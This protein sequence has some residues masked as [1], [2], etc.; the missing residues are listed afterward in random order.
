MRCSP[1]GLRACA[2][3]IV[4]AYRRRHNFQLGDIAEHQR[5][6]RPMSDRISAIRRFSLLPAGL[7][8]LGQLALAPIHAG[9]R[10][11][12]VI[13]NADY[14]QAPLRNPVNDAR[15]LGQTLERLGFEVIRVENAT[16]TRMEQAVIEFTSR[17]KANTSGVFYYAGHGVQVKGRNYLIPV[18][19]TLDSEREVRLEA[20]DVDLV[21]GELEYAGNR[22][23]IV[24]LDACRNNPFER[25]FR[26]RSRGLAAIDA[27]RGTLIAYATAPGSVAMD[28][29]GSNGVYTEELL[30]A[31]NEPGLEVEEVFKQVRIRVSK[32]T[33]NQQIPWESSS[34]TGE[35]VFHPG[36]P[37]SAAGGAAA[38]SRNAELLFWESVKASDNADVYRAY[39]AQY[40]DGLFTSLARI[41]LAELEGTKAAARLS[42]SAPGEGAAAPAPA[43][44][45]TGAGGSGSQQI[46]ALAPPPGAGGDRE[47]SGPVKV[48]LLPPNTGNLCGE[49]DARGEVSSVAGSFFRDHADLELTHAYQG[50]RLGGAELPYADDYW[51]GSYTVKVPNESA[52]YRVGGST[53]ADAALMYVYG[54]VLM[55]GAWDGGTG[56]VSVYLFDLRTQTVYHRE[57]T[58]RDMRENTEQVVQEYLRGRAG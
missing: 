21:L 44:T 46:A 5:S 24:I 52:V 34:L 33:N 25:R 11:A 50:A 18:D 28:G 49:C 4:F 39:L 58:R 30:H 38:A 54:S 51:Q 41:R 27:A 23:N 40:P 31:L 7:V 45:A 13:G 10:V 16:R 57:G 53:D 29:D 6:H 32:R 47:S 17:L 14:A 15:A 43:G 35:F 8:L 19:A 3:A 42:A 22:L 36:A 12:L 26:G 48:A 56:K 20:M 55:K 9:E 2:W 37:S 1:E